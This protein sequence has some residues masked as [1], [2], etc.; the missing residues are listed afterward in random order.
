MTQDSNATAPA[1]AE[2]NPASLDEFMSR[3]PA[4][5]SDAELDTMSGIFRRQRLN[6]EKV[7]AAGAA[8]KAPK[9]AKVKTTLG[10]LGLDD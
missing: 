2:A 5:L 7:Q 3:D 8:S 1:L 10:D 6:W 4:G 9:G